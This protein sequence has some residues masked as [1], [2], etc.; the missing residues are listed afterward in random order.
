M[1]PLIILILAA[2]F[3]TGCAT[4]PAITTT[5]YV[6]IKPPSE[7]VKDCLVEAPPAIEKYLSVSFSEKEKLLYQFSDTQLNNLAKCNKQWKSLRAW[8]SSQDLL[9]K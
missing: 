4:A 9:Y 3:L 8:I 7:M 2:A 1:K 6:L 5:Q